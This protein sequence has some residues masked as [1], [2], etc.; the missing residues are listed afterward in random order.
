[1]W[2]GGQGRPYP[3]IPSFPMRHA[4]GTPEA[5]ISGPGNC[6]PEAPAPHW[7]WDR[8][9]LVEFELLL[10]VDHGGDRGVIPYVP[11]L[12]HSRSA[13]LLRKICRYAA[14]FQG[15]MKSLQRAVP[16]RQPRPA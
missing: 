3:A 12:E 1:M 9:P 6:G 8:H 13:A 15:Y 2:G 11:A 5:A 7:H 16:C 4:L 10:D 14:R